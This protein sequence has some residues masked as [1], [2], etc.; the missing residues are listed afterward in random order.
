MIHELR[1]PARGLPS[2]KVIL[3]PPTQRLQSFWERGRFYE[4]NM[5]MY[6]YERYR[7]GVFVDVGSNIGNHTLFFAMYCNPSL[8][9]SI[10][11]VVSYLRHQ[12]RNLALNDLGSD[13]VIT[14]AVAVSD[15]PGTGKMVKGEPNPSPRARWAWHRGMHELREGAGATTVTTLDLLLPTVTDVTLI[16]MDIEGSELKALAGAAALLERERPT[17]FLETVSAKIGQEYA[18]FL[19]QFGYDSGRLIYPKIFEFRAGSK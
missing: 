7:G 5:L 9:I 1:P 13:Q 4:H 3:K 2:T 18:N 11:P 16:K 14:H 17:L 12:R 6:V 8:V 10:E 19:R 15:R